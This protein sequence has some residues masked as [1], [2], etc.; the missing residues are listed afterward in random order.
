MSRNTIAVAEHLANIDRT[1]VDVTAKQLFEAIDRD[2]DGSVDAAEFESAYKSIKSA[3]QKEHA[4][5]KALEDKVRQSKRR[6]KLCSALAAFAFVI[7]VVLLAGN[8]GLVYMMMKASRETFVSSASLIDREGHTVQTAQVQGETGLAELVAMGNLKEIAALKEIS[9]VDHDLEGTMDA[10]MVTAPTRSM[11]VVSWSHAGDR[12]RA[13]FYGP[14]EEAVL[15]DNGNVMVVGTPNGYATSS[16]KTDA[17]TDAAELQTKC[18]ASSCPAAQCSARTYHGKITQLLCDGHGIWSWPSGVTLASPETEGRRKLGAVD[19]F[20]GATLGGQIPTNYG[21]GGGTATKAQCEAD[22]KSKKN[23]NC[24]VWN[25]IK[26][27]CTAMTCKS[28]RG[29]NWGVNTGS[30]ASSSASSSAGSSAGSSVGSSTGTAGNKCN[31]PTTWACCASI[32]MNF[33]ML[34]AKCVEKKATSQSSIA[35]SN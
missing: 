23:G 11:A 13:I 22:N 35:A 29:M 1:D 10:D 9:Y 4:N 32:G 14:K 21:T 27:Y 26:K 8:A 12:P 3:I 25:P 34:A 20:A 7:I 19:K 28:T 33:N 24:W 17:N 18:A 30:S 6:V 31:Y 16:Y 5:E 15:V 2:G